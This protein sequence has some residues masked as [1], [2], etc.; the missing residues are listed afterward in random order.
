MCHLK[1]VPLTHH[2]TLQR[3]AF[4]GHHIIPQCKSSVPLGSAV[5]SSST[6]LRAAPPPRAAHLCHTSSVFPNIPIL[7][8]PEDLWA[9]SLKLIQDRILPSFRTPTPPSL[10]SLLQ[11]CVLN[12]LAGLSPFQLTL[13][14]PTVFLIS[15][16]DATRR[17]VRGRWWGS[18]FYFTS[19]VILLNESNARD[20]LPDQRG[21][22]IRVSYLRPSSKIVHVV[23][24]LSP[25]PHS[26]QNKAEARTTCQHPLS[27]SSQGSAD[28]CPREG[29]AS[30]TAQ[31]FTALALSLDCCRFH[32]SPSPAG[33]HI[34][35][36][37]VT[38]T[39]SKRH[40]WYQ[41]AFATSLPAR[42][43]QRLSTCLMDRTLGL[44]TMPSPAWG[45]QESPAALTTPASQHR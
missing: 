20:K 6:T 40:F 8:L 3:K 35:L 16:A 41:Q 26:P 1:E 27:Q 5:C 24:T 36:R 13:P 23:P 18:A 42:A 2:I 15:F 22:R 28:T 7:C 31:A 38:V 29:F 37:T 21:E 25:K 17:P 9:R 34:I 19:Q 30:H 33:P 14:C 39:E 43:T 12:S 11:P 10:R 44:P 4:Q 32:P 45:C